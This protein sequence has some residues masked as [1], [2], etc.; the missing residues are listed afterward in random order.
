MKNFRQ[1][2]TA[3]AIALC[4][5]LTLSSCNDDPEIDYW[6]AGKPT[7][8]PG[9]GDAQFDRAGLNI[10]VNIKNAEKI[11]YAVLAATLPTEEVPEPEIPVPGEEDYKLLP[12]Y[13]V[14][15]GIMSLPIGEFPKFGN[16]Y[17]YF[18]ASN[19]KYVTTPQMIEV[20]YSDT[21]LEEL[22]TYE[23]KNITPFS[24][25][26]DVKMK[27]L[28]TKYV[29]TVIKQSAYNETSFISQ[30]QSSMN[31]SSSQIQ[32]G[33]Q[34][35]VVFTEDAL[36]SELELS[37]NTRYNS[38]ECEGV[39]LQRSSDI[40]DGSG[41]T[42]SELTKYMVAIYGVDIH[43]RGS[44]YTSEAFTLPEPTYSTTTPTIEIIPSI[45]FT[46][47]S[48]TYKAT[49]ECAK[50]VYGA[51]EA[52][53]SRAGRDETFWE[54]SNEANIQKFLKAQLA[55]N[56]PVKNTPAGFSRELPVSGEP[57]MKLVTY[58]FGITPDGKLGPISYKVETCK[59]A[60]LNGTAKIT[61]LTFNKAINAP[62]PQLSWKI[63][64]TANTTKLRFLVADITNYEKTYGSVAT[65]NK[66]YLNWMM[67]THES[68]DG[69]GWWREYTVAELA[70]TGNI[71][72]TKNLPFYNKDYVIRVI[73][74][75]TYGNWGEI[76]SA[77]NQKTL[78]EDYVD[79]SIDFSKGI[80]EITVTIKKMENIPS[81]D[82]RYSTS[83]AI[84]SITKGANTVE[85]YIIKL[86]D[87]SKF[88]DHAS[89]NYTNLLPFCQ[90]QMDTE[91][92]LSWPTANI[93]VFGQD[94]APASSV[95]N[96][97]NAY[98]VSAHIFITKDTAG[99]Y[100]IAGIVAA[101][102]ATPIYPSVN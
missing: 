7:L 11:H 93:V 4:A 32:Y 78:P 37:K 43:G 80:G 100:K 102:S 98:G 12:A 22:L 16:Y 6:G 1:F 83:E 2:M 62:Y 27:E 87:N 3:P 24:L 38:Q 92:I 14:S 51:M 5:L 66:E 70:A 77:P 39:L 41:S 79:K 67:S 25:N 35:F 53:D 91:S 46:K 36:I 60:V 65:E 54:P 10:P 49:G 85:A 26:V 71:F 94:Y 31:P 99:N 34:A 56:V 72:S 63:A 52:E 96:N 68:P 69:Y 81:E 18:Y 30:A 58:A 44:V 75:D 20:A 89:L 95:F 15:E 73:A 90:K 8:T 61:E 42:T 82:P 86:Q 57:G 17:V 13:A 50:I 33:K 28:C 64:Y 40:S 48:A 74:Q 21:G 88:K 76:K 23:I 59:K 9:G 97:P 55:S 101:G 29:A 84:Y 45:T 19:P 47:L